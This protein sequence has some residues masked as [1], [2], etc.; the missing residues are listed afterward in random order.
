MNFII[1]MMEAGACLTNR[2]PS[3]FILTFRMS[4]AVDFILSNARRA[5]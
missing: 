1:G 2:L 3:G 5:A 4:R